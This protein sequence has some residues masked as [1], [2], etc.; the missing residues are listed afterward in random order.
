MGDHQLAA[1]IAESAIGLDPLREVGHC[2]LIDAEVARGDRGA[3]LTAFARCQRILHE[4][5]VVEPSADTKRVIE[6][7]R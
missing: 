5:L 4:Q 1:T 2:R 6:Q 7:L 3:A